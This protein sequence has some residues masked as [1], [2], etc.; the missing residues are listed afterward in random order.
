MRD[1]I[2]THYTLLA[3]TNLR[4][5]YC[6]YCAPI[7]RTYDGFRLDIDDLQ[8]SIFASVRAIQITRR[9]SALN[10]LAL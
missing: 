4:A 5:I 6:A 3:R 10:T 7:S 8:I 2:S 1:L 9:Y